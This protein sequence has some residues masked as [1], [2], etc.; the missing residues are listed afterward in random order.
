MHLAVTCKNLE[1]HKEKNPFHGYR[2]K[3]PS[4][5]TEPFNV[6]CDLCG[7]VYLYH[8]QDVLDMAD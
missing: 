5:P 2:I 4:R 3:V 8:P 6:K 7:K 1:F